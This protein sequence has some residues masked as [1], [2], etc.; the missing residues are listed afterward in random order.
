[1]SLCLIEEGIMLAESIVFLSASFNNVWLLNVTLISFIELLELSFYNTFWN[2]LPQ[3]ANICS[4]NI[5]N[6]IWTNCCD[7]NYNQTFALLNAPQA[8]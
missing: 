6:R 3:V 2:C 1:M 4:I 5:T 7:Q 8:H